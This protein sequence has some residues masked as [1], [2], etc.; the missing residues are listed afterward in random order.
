MAKK[1]KYS[2]EADLAKIALYAVNSGSPTTILTQTVTEGDTTHAPSG[3]AVYNSL[4]LKENLSTIQYVAASATPLQL[5]PTSPEIIVVTGITNQIIILPDAT[6]VSILPVG[7]SR[8]FKIV[9]VTNFLNPPYTVIIKDFSGNA[10]YELYSDE[11]YH[12]SFTLFNDSTQAGG[13]LLE[14]DLTTQTK[15]GLMSVETL[16]KTSNVNKAQNLD[17]IANNGVMDFYYSYALSNNLVNAKQI[18]FPDF[19]NFSPFST[20]EDPDGTT[21]IITSK[22]TA[23]EN[24]EILAQSTTTILANGVSSNSL[25]VEPGLEYKC[26]F[27]KVADIIEIF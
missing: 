4:L 15:A 8:R 17:N 19:K 23:T 9:N 25:I 21:I 13:W 27:N 22:N 18:K 11:L 6:D 5:V 12:A 2:Q 26:I 14:Y 16:T 20:D 24:L 1:V 7:W 10:I 3:D